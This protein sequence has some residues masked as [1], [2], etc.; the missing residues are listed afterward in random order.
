[1]LLS[2]LLACLAGKAA[3]YDGSENG[4]TPRAFQAPDPWQEL[5]SE[6]PA[7]PLEENLVDTGV[8]PGGSS[9]RIYVDSKSLTVSEDQIVHYTV[10]VI[11]ED[12]IW[13]VTNEGLH[14]G[15][16][17]YRRYAYGVNGEWQSL[18]DTPW[19]PLEG[20]G[21]NAYRKTF[22]MHYMCVPSGPYLQPEQIL[23]KFRS[24][25]MVIDE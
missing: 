23:R 3:G 21:I 19:Q 20:V 24:R 15:N 4:W 10:V 8:R 5:D 14:C 1:M 25:R 13:N 2:C 12:G 22:Y 18:G 17:V 9:Y 7:Y 6:L 11:S 16:K